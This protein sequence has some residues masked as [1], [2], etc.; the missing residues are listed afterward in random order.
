M[1][2]RRRSRAK[3]TRAVVCIDEAG[4]HQP[5]RAAGL[6]DRQ[7]RGCFSQ[8]QSHPWGKQPRNVRRRPAA[9]L[10]LPWQIEASAAKK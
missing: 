10:R 1:S 5:A 3:D 2:Q 8:L 6:G 4:G 9:Q 7:H